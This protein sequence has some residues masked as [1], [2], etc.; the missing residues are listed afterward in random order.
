MAPSLRSSALSRM[1]LCMGVKP[2]RLVCREPARLLFA[3]ILAYSG[4]AAIKQLEQ[5]IGVF[6]ARTRPF[7]VKA[8][9][10]G[11]LAV[12]RRF[13]DELHELERRLVGRVSCR[14]FFRGIF[15]HFAGLRLQVAV[16]F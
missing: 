9:S 7:G 10:G 2:R 15:C 8:G 11:S 13:D 6:L 5:R 14:S 12:T 1:G 16:R 4:A 3:G